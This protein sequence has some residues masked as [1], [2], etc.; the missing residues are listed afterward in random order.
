MEKLE[1]IF[2]KMLFWHTR[3]TF[4]NCNDWKYKSQ[5]PILGEYAI[6][7]FSI[8]IGIG[9]NVSDFVSKVTLNPMKQNGDQKTR[10]Y[11]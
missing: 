4:S 6:G 7:R 5:T 8:Y 9:G 1:D 11:F 3:R 2:K 10:R